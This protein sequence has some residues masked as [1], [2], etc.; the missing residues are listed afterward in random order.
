MVQFLFPSQ[1]G[2]KGVLIDYYRS[3]VEEEQNRKETS[4][5]HRE[6]ITKKSA[7]VRTWVRW[8]SECISFLVERVGLQFRQF[9]IGE[10]LGNS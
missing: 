4:R 3:Q 1:T 8:R 6:E 5:K 9:V 10:L 2:P 7:T